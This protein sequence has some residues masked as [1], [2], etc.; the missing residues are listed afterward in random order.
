MVAKYLG[1]I[2]DS[3][4]ELDEPDPEAQVDDH[5]HIRVPAC[6]L[7]GLSAKHHKR[8]GERDVLHHRTNDLVMFHRRHT[9]IS[10]TAVVIDDDVVTTDQGH[11]RVL[12]E[13]LH[14]MR[15]SCWE[16]PIVDVLHR[17]EF[18]A[19]RFDG[20]VQGLGPTQPARREDADPMLALG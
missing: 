16:A 12:V 8:V 4:A 17:Y 10:L 6:V 18:S 20:A 2:G 1:D 7:P 14:L 9:D 15:Q 19:R 5:R 3:P 13:E 11:S